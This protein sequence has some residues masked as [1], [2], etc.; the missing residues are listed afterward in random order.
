MTISRRVS[1]RPG[2]GRSK[3]A[4]SRALP[5]GGRNECPGRV[6][7]MVDHG[8]TAD[9]LAAL[10]GL[11]AGTWVILRDYHHPRRPEI[12]RR[13]AALCRRYR[14]VFLIG[15]DR[16]LARRVG[17]DGVHL[18]EAAIRRGGWH[19]RG[20]IVTAAAHSRSSA[21]RAVRNGAD[22]VLVSPAFATRS[23][24]GRDGLG[25]HR[26]QRMAAG[27]PRPVI[28]L[29]GVTPAT[30]PRLPPIVQG[31]AAIDGLAD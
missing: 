21:W 5:R 29:G 8:R 20:L 18:P 9:P 10:R 4:L 14:L 11:P 25:P 30:A 7:Y 24:P 3:S 19:R 22:A 27:L 26:L 31:I 6:I 15:G 28:A 23:H 12:A 17:A 16:R 13:A 1:Y 2:A